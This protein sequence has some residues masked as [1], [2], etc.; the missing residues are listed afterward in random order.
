MG[1][2]DDGMKLDAPGSASALSKLETFKYV[3]SALLAMP[4][5]FALICCKTRQQKQ[6]LMLVSK[7]RLEGRF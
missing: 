4:L 7:S 5:G 2:A 6:Y 3:G 1:D